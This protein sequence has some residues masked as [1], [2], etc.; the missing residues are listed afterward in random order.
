[1]LRPERQSAASC[2]GGQQE[3]R[4]RDERARAAGQFYGG[5]AEVIQKR[6]LDLETELLFYGIFGE[7]VVRPQAFAGV[8]RDGPEAGDQE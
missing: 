5:E 8:G 6:G 1:M 7:L 4:G 2:A 3:A